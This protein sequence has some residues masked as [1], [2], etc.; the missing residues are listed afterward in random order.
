MVSRKS[1]IGGALYQRERWALFQVIPRIFLI[2]K[3][4]PCHVYSDLMPLKQTIEQVANNNIQQSNQL[5]KRLMHYQETNLVESG[6]YDH[7][8]QCMMDSMA[9]LH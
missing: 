7:S 8:H 4:C 9:K 2:T 5:W 1:F 3:E 6:L